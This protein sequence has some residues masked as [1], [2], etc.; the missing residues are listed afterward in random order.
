MRIG[1]G[2]GAPN[3]ILEQPQHTC[4][5]ATQRFRMPLY[6]H[7]LTVVRF[8]S[9]RHTITGTGSD[10]QP[11]RRHVHALMMRRIGKHRFRPKQA[12]KPTAGLQCNLMQRRISTV[13]L[14]VQQRMLTE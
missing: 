6:K 10:L 14:C 12:G 4:I 11:R 3:K 8:Q 1:I 2:S 13:P 5:R 7:N 9:L